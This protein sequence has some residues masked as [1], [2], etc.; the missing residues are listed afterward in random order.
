MPDDPAASSHL[1]N[2]HQRNAWLTVETVSNQPRE[3]IVQAA[4]IFIQ[5]KEK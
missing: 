5:F 3:E 4:F 1:E 2:F